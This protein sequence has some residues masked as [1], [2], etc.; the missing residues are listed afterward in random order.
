M[1]LF[2]ENLVKGGIIYLKICI[3]LVGGV[4]PE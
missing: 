2:K 4:Y 1:A 3:L